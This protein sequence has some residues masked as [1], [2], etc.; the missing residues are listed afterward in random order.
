M[1][2]IVKQSGGFIWVESEIGR[3][4]TFSIYLPRVDAAADE[5][6]Q[7]LAAAPVAPPPGVRVLLVE[8]DPGVRGLMAELLQGAGY[9]VSSAARP[10]EALAIASE[11]AFDMLITD[12]IMPEMSGRELAQAIA[13]ERP[14]LPV[15]FVSGYAGDAIARHGGIGPG[16][17]FLQ[18]P[19]GEADLLQL[20]GAALSAS[21][22][23]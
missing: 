5:L 9:A 16:E 23:T 19:F 7:P 6:P 20:V 17:W 2:G 18:K 13:G 14:G 12:I 21:S 22:R 11:T 8:D 4:T 3:G 15:V 10:S 1:Y